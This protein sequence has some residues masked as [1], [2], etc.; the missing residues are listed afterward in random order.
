MRPI[1]LDDLDAVVGGNGMCTA[2]DPDGTAGQAVIT[3]APWPTDQQLSD[4]QQGIT[5]VERGVI[6]A[7]DKAMAPW[8]LFN[9][10]FGGF[11]APSLTYKP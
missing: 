8:K 7:T 11:R 4:Y 9:G 5:P 10:L 3:A 6:D 1:D 2:D